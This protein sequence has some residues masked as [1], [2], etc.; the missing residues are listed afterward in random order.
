MSRSASPLHDASAA[1]PLASPRPRQQERGGFAGADEKGLQSALTSRLL[2]AIVVGSVLAIGTVHVRVLL[3]V[4]TVTF[5]TLALAF[6]RSS[7]YRARLAL[8]WPAA[9]CFALAAYCLLQAAPMPIAWLRT[10][11]PANADVWDRCL[12]PFGEQGPSWAPVS[13]DP[14]ASLVE[15][16]KWATYAAV[17][18]VS[19]H[20]AAARGAT[21]GV[22]TVFFAALAAALVTLAHGLAGA[23]AVYGLY[24]PTF[25]LAPWHIG[26]L[27]NGNNLA[28][29]LN[30]GA[31]AGTGLLIARRPTLPRWAL[32]PAIAT[33][34]GVEITSASRGGVLSLPVGLVTVALLVRPNR[35][36]E[37][38][39][40]RATSS[41]I[42]LT[43]AGGT[44][45]AGLGGTY[46]VWSELSERSLLKVSM[47]TWAKPLV[48]DHPLLGIGRGAFESVFPLYRQHPGNVVF[49]HAENFP[50]QWAAEW[51]IPV[52]LA[53]LGAFAWAM[54]PRRM[55]IRHSAI[56]AGAWV[57]VVVVLA[58]NLFDLA[59]EVPGVCI[60]LAATLGSLW[61]ESHRSRQS[62]TVEQRVLSSTQSSAAAAGA[63]A[64]GLGLVG[65]AAQLGMHDVGSERTH[66]QE[67]LAAPPQAVRA[68]ASSLRDE[69]RRS[70]MRHP[71]ESYFPLVGALLAHR[72]GGGNPMLWLQRS[73]ER[74][75]VN[76]RA[77][78]LLAEVLAA[79][80][81]RQQAL[82]EL[83]RCALDDDALVTRA[84]AAATRHARTFED[85]LQAVPDGRAG[86]AML[87]A[88]GATLATEPAAEE[89][90]AR[91]DREAIF[92]DPSLLDPRIREADAKIRAIASRTSAGCADRKVCRAEIL[93]QAD[94]IAAIVPDRSVAT[95]IRARLL[96]ADGNAT[97][98]VRL[99][100]ATCNQ[101]SDRVPCLAVRVQAAA[102]VKAPELLDAA[103]KDLLSA[104]CMSAVVCAENASWLASLRQ[105]RGERGAA[106]ALLERAARES[107]SNDA[108]W[109]ALATAASA[110]GAHARALEALEAV[111]RLRGTVDPDLR[112]RIDAARDAA[113]AGLLTP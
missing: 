77:H 1:R 18:T 59:L 52:A 60:A 44:L 99:L 86:A 43:A 66:F 85:L 84:A 94:A 29:Y 57:G 32:A 93:A 64:A 7:G 41:V 24:S 75:P 8:P 113:M 35:R 46:G 30:L 51:G 33:I 71:A 97:E 21:Y 20:V 6:S 96:A 95:Q 73:L 89:L 50:A 101:A 28:G 37:P 112:K 104:V 26:P 82:A 36:A 87:A 61:G 5:A 56:A 98:A 48:G 62:A 110:A 90:R 55:G 23:T 11:A 53:A 69:L 65:G 91:S 34:I 49:T 19:V 54:A 16:L 100:A 109:M 106:V 70:M 58:Q 3:M 2:S 103:S 13:L 80:G 111:A 10:I 81:A 22:A 15:A 72:V 68:S 67:A 102:Q 79:R 63:M 25:A 76:G 45:L 27:L 38:A 4:A 88:V 39:T 40:V 78:L 108:R 14:G 17:F 74:A 83:R 47:L 105:E 92:R 107:P 12:L 31:L 42:L 9:V